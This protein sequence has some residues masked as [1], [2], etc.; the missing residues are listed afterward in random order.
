MK[1]KATDSRRSATMRAVK[2]VDTT[3][4]MIV[5]RLAHR[6][7]YRYRLHKK[8]LP[9]KPDLVFVGLRKIIFVNGCFWHSHNC[10]RGSRLPKTNREYWQRK[11]AGNVARD[12]A[13]LVALEAVGWSV[14]TVWECETKVSVSQSVPVNS[15][16]RDARLDHEALPLPAS[17]HE[18]YIDRI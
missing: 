5:R 15:R 16:K 3:P 18:Q 12:Q 9:G 7:G 6:L 11:I 2:S 17:R 1:A 13:T 14:F 4:E 8:D 10:A